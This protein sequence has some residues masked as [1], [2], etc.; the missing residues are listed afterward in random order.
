[1]GYNQKLWGVNATFMEVLSLIKGAE[2]AFQYKLFPIIMETDSKELI[3][4]LMNNQDSVFASL[5][6]Q[7]RYW[8]RKLQNLVIQHSFREGK[9]VAHVLA[10]QA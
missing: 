8:L 10:N 9:K 1:M 3:S 2:I 4:L 7:C 6:S 5:I